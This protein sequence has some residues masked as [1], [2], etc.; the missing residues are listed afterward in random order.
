MANH[1]T[2]ARS[3]HEPQVI[4]RDPDHPDVEVEWQVEDKA[5]VGPGGVCLV[6]YHTRTGVSGVHVF[7]NPD[8]L[9]MVSETAGA[10]A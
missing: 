3:L 8:E 6:D 2:H 1:P 10:A 4:R 7:L 9:V 5:H